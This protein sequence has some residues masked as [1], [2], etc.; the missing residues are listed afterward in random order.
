MKY[1]ILTTWKEELLT[2]AVIAACLALFFLFPAQ[3]AAQGVTSS[4]IFLFLIPF[5]YLKLILKKNLKDYGWQLGNWKK[6]LLFASISLVAALL[7]FYALYHYTPLSKMY[8]LPSFAAGNFWL[9]LLYEFI[10]VSFFLALYEFFFRGFVLFS[11]L[12]KTGWFSIL[13]QFAIFLIFLAIAGNLVWQNSFYI[14]IAAFAGLTTLKSRSLVYSFAF[15]LLFSLISDAIL[16]KL[17]Y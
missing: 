14:I 10:L 16:I 17:L 8:R 4:L 15:G 2:T 13:I 5:L 6:G 12:P 3:G 7:I 11:F 9:F 1:T